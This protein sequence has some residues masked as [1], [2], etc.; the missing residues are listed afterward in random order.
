MLTAPCHPRTL[1]NAAF[2]IRAH[3]VVGIISSGAVTTSLCVV[4]LIVATTSHVGGLMSVPTVDKDCVGGEKVADRFTCMSTT[5]DFIRAK[6][7]RA[8]ACEEHERTHTS[9]YSNPAIHQ[10]SCTATAAHTHTHTHTH[11]HHPMA[12]NLRVLSETGMLQSSDGALVHVPVQ[13]AVAD[14]AAHISI[15]LPLAETRCGGKIASA[16]PGV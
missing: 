7:K 4:L 5:H 1:I 13:P 2:R 12:H 14:R 8:R 6:T 16:A 9:Q 11:T 10:H 3:G 15:G